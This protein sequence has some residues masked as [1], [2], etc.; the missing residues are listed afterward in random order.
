M[1]NSLQSK[2]S[3]L[4]SKAVL[5]Q[6]NYESLSEN[7]A[8]SGAKPNWGG[9]SFVPRDIIVINEHQHRST[10][11]LYLYLNISDLSGFLKLLEI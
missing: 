11:R 5:M 8:T 3:V 4:Y 9:A 10:S 2:A 7:Y 6:I 1:H